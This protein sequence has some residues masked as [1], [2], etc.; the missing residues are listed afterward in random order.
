M[1][2]ER[3]NTSGTLNRNESQSQLTTSFEPMDQREVE[4][5]A[6]SG[7]NSQLFME[8]QFTNANVP[9]MGRFNTMDGFGNNE[10]DS[11]PAQHGMSIP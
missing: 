6:Q 5:R 4:L 9:M 1:Q 11:D 10:F 3:K 8:S 2:G 7:E